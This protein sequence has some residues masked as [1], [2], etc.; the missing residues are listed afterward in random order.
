MV[1]V[2]VGWCW[3]GVQA[4]VGLAMGA[5]ARQGAKVLVLAVRPL[6][7]NMGQVTAR[8]QVGEFLLV[9]VVVGVAAA[10]GLDGVTV[11]RPSAVGR[12]SENIRSISDM[13]QI[14]MVG[15]IDQHHMKMQQHTGK[16]R[17]GGGGDSSRWWEEEDYLDYEPGGHKG[18]RR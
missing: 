10:M 5:A 12:S 4:L 7:L 16:D 14:P 1:V 11:L 6:R 15:T 2:V 13:G 18:G 8:V 17:G 3:D 9:G